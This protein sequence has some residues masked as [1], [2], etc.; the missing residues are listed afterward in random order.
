MPLANAGATFVIGV[1]AYE[2]EKTIM[3]HKQVLVARTILFAALFGYGCNQPGSGMDGGPVSDSVVAVGADV[4]A[5]GAFLLEGEAASG[6]GS[7][8]PRSEASG[9]KTRLL[10]AG[11]G[12]SW[13]FVATVG[14]KY[15]VTARYS[16]DGGSALEDVQLIFDDTSVGGFTAENTRASG[17]SPGEGWNAFLTTPDIG[18]VNVVEG[19]NTLAIQVTGG[20]GYGVEI[21]WVKLSLAE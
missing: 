13:S 17:M 3:M 1:P 8:M 9:A 12:A 4:G 18:V 15:A 5:A 21:D 6:S 11:E 20:D 10:H 19:S 16:N 2:E 14:G 7:A